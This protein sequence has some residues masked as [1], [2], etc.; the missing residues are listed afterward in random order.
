[1]PTACDLEKQVKILWLRLP[2]CDK[3]KFLRHMDIWS[4]YD[5]YFIIKKFTLHEQ[6]NEV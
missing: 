3:I 5:V 4:A 2:S 1:M 6:L